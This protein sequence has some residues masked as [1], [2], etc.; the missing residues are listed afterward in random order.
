MSESRQS[1]GAAERFRRLMEKH[2]D[3]RHAWH[4]E[5]EAE[6]RDQSQAEHDAEL[7]DCNEWRRPWP[8]NG[9]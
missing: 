9:F 4:R 5:R 8:N 6:A 1:S 2:E 3:E 7:E